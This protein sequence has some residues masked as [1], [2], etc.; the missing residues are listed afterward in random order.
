MRAWPLAVFVA[1][2][3]A[4]SGC[5]SEGGLGAFA[6][7]EPDFD[8]T[9]AM[10]EVQQGSRTGGRRTT[11]I[12]ASLLDDDPFWPY[13]VEEPVGACRFSLRVSPSCDSDCTGVCVEGFCT[14]PPVPQEAGEL[15]VTTSSVHRTLSFGEA[16]YSDFAD[17]PLFAPGDT[18]TVRASGGAVPA[19]ELAARMP[20]PIRLNDVGNFQVKRG[21]SL[22]LRWQPADPE[23]R[24]RLLL[25]A[26]LYHASYR[27]ALIECDLPDEWGGVTIPR[28]MMD[29]FL[30]PDLWGCGICIPHSLRRYNRVRGTAGDL[31][32]TLWASEMHAFNLW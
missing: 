27:S 29:R 20:E 28:A 5:D 11:T 1:P 19:F 32:L 17:E 21:E 6:D 18:V 23:S 9:A 16:G 4:G 10:I 12:V 3:L 30:D 15:T 14:D 25:G 31:A 24:V 26:D 8:D 13:E 2:V 22:T 7:P